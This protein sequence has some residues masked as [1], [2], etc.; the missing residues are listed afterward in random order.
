MNGAGLATA[1]DELF[2]YTPA[3]AYK[4]TVDRGYKLDAYNRFNRKWSSVVWEGSETEIARTLSREGP[5]LAAGQIDAYWANVFHLP[6]QTQLDPLLATLNTYIAGIAV[7]T[8][9]LWFFN[10]VTAYKVTNCFQ[11]YCVSSVARA[12]N[13]IFGEW[14]PILESGDLADALHVL[15]DGAP[16][17][18]I[19]DVGTYWSRLV[20]NIVSK[21]V[22]GVPGDLVGTVISDAVGLTWKNNGGQLGSYIYRN[23]IKIA[24][25]GKN[26]TSYLDSSLQGSTFLYY[27]V[28]FNN[29]GISLPSNV[30][31]V[32]ISSTGSIAVATCGSAAHG[33]MASV[34]TA[35]AG[36]AVT[37]VN[38][39]V[40][41]IGSATGTSTISAVRAE[42]A[43]SIGTA[44]GTSGITFSAV[45]ISH[46]TSILG[47]L[48]GTG[49]S[50]ASG[51]SNAIVRRT[52]SATGMS[53]GSAQTGSGNVYYVALTGNDNT[54]T[55]SSANPWRTPQYA[56]QWLT[57]GD[58]LIIR[59]GTYVAW[60]SGW[61]GPN[62]GL[63]SLIAGTSGN[64][65][66]IEADPNAPA[67]SVIINGRN[68]KVAV[69]I[70][71]EPG[72][73]WIK[74]IG[75]TQTDT[76][77]ACTKAGIKY[78]G[79]NGIIQG[80]T[81]DGTGG[82]GGIF[83]DFSDNTQILNNTVLNCIGTNTTGHGM[84]ISGTCTGVIVRGN[85]IHDNGY[86]GLHV[87]GDV[88]EGG[89][90]L[91]QNALIEDNVIYNNGQ[92][93]INTDGLAN[94]TIRNNLIYTYQK[95][96][97]IL[98]QIDAG[99][100]S[101]GNII[102]NNTIVST[103][104]G[105][106]AA[107]GLVNAATNNTIFNN[108]LLGGDG[109]S[110]R[111]ST[112]SLPGLASNYNVVTNSFLNDDT[113]VTK[114]LAQWRSTY[115]TD[116]NSLIATSNQLFVNTAESDYHLLIAAPATNAGTSTDAPSGDLDGNV[117][118]FGTG[119]DVGCYEN[120]VAQSLLASGNSTAAAL[121]I[122]VIKSV[123]S[124]SGGTA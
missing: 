117:R 61:D 4:I 54:G 109:N 58:T 64:P 100:P 85:T 69:G 67:G 31:V 51:M 38:I 121:R 16:F 82:I 106:V 122:I 83:T 76:G 65:I 57:P 48:A 77:G 103:Y 50:S 86:V 62:A 120:Q 108:I 32:R 123:G 15:G 47:G 19:S 45:G 20:G 68:N 39:L 37:G 23:N 1:S 21:V 6:H 92:N 74:L 87:N 110:Y 72:C 91:V 114:T 56:V 99:S 41:A 3:I 8:S 5:F 90:G 88:S 63:Y 42:L 111:I 59:Q 118:P 53:V 7:G 49:T 66:T 18:D 105:S 93:G 10:T 115:G 107:I 113:S 55:G 96:G 78:T 119:F 24:T 75:L 70:D 43:A 40:Y 14:I 104:P 73:D 101:T 102:V 95:H 84:Y 26:T 36:S 98:Y 116:V 89:I 28:A 52:G 33:Q 112:D 94:S 79:A 9:E 44:S 12:S 35:V 29:S 81:V 124:A 71:F 46:G 34:A 30:V 11:K 25:V 22:L 2:F 80:C 27:I 13:D 60:I 17:L 97:I